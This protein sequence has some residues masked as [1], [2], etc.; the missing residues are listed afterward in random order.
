[1]RTAGV[2]NGKHLVWGLLVISVLLSLVQNPPISLARAVGDA[3]DIARLGEVEAQRKVSGPLSSFTWQLIGV[4]P[5]DACVQLLYPEIEPNQ[6]RR[7]YT[8][9]LASVLAHGL[10][11]RPVRVVTHGH[12]AV[13]G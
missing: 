4:V 12:D 9:A 5:G 2:L 3:V 8:V 1:M 7:P 6:S 10:H 11:P 13:F